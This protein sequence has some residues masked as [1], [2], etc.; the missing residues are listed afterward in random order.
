MADINDI[1]TKKAHLKDTLR[2][3][4]KAVEFNNI[5][6]GIGNNDILEGIAYAANF[7][8]PIFEAFSS[9]FDLPAENLVPLKEAMKFGH[10]DFTRLPMNELPSFSLPYHEDELMTILFLIGRPYFI[11][12]RN[13]FKT[14][15]DVWEDG[16]CPVCSAKHSL[17]SID[18]ENKRKLFCSFCGASGYYKRIGCPVCRSSDTSKLNIIT[19]EDEKGFRIDTCDSCDSYVKTVESGLINELNPDVADLVSLPL[20]IIAQGKSYK[21]HSPNPIGMIRM[22]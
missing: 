7:V 12:L 14:G 3:Y 8:E 16:K 15:S 18:E 17:G 22:A 10:V 5:V 21:R 20:D 13:S 1:I 6:Q 9:V 19:L 4:E 2:L 11:H